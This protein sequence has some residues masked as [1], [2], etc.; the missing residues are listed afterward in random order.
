MSK[1]EA[2]FG[3]R[4]KSTRGGARA[5]SRHAFL[6]SVISVS[7]AERR[8]MLLLLTVFAATALALAA[9]GIYGVM[10]YSVSLRT[11]E[12]GVRMALGASRRSVL[13]LVVSEGIIFTATGM[14]AGITA[15]LA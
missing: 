14:V 3:W 15:A 12:L 13:R 4:P 10:S 9:A 8:F 5:S 11:H 7:L 2:I 1:S 6:R